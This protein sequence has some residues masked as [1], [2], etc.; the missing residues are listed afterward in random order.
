MLATCERPAGV[1]EGVVTGDAGFCANET[2]RRIPNTGWPA[3]FAMS[4]TR[5]CT[6]GKYVRDLL[7]HLPRPCDGRRATDAPD[8]RRR[9]CWVC[10]RRATRNPLGAVTIVRAK[11]RRNHGPKHVSLFVTNLLEGKAGTVLSLSGWH[12][13]VEVTRAARQSG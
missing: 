1:T 7:G 12:W 3:V 5:T 8:G 13:G 6:K 2:L 4:R 11:K 9:D 10:Q